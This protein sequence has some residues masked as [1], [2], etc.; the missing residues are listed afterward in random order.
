MI[1][2]ILVYILLVP[3]EDIDM[4]EVV[5]FLLVQLISMNY[6]L[7]VIFY[8]YRRLVLLLLLL[9]HVDKLDI[10][11]MIL[12]Y[13]YYYYRINVVVVYWRILLYMIYKIHDCMVLLQQLQN[14]YYQDYYISD[15]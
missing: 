11:K 5:L 4:Q 2:K 1:V 8:V 13:Y 14:L 9:N 15:I 3:F 10:D 6:Y 12:I 7:F